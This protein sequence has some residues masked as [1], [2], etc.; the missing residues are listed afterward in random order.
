MPEHTL[1]I[2]QLDDDVVYFSFEVAGRRV[3]CMTHFE[4]QGEELHLTQLHLDG[5]ARNLVG[6][7]ALWEAAYQL[8]RYFGVKTLR[9]EGGRR[10]T[11]RYKGRMPTPLTIIIPAV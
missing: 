1:I 9:V 11:G 7:A 2:E 8:G 3:E 10:A 4:R 5:D 6:R